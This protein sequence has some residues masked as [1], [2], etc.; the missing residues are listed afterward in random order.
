MVL[1]AMWFSSVT[2]VIGAIMWRILTKQITGIDL[3]VV[4]VALMITG[5]LGLS[6]STGM[7]LSSLRRRRVANGA[8]IVS[9]E[10]RSTGEAVALHS[11]ATARRSIQ[12]DGVREIGSPWP[13][14]TMSLV[15]SN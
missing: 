14:P 3:R 11:V 5:A 4:A 13:D 10:M 2:G 9:S 15:S 6:V 7:F 8:V 1:R 12:S